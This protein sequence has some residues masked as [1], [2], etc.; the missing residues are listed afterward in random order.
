MVDKPPEPESMTHLCAVDDSCIFWINESA[1]TGKTTIAYTVAEVCKRSHVLSASL[2]CSCDDAECSNPLL[3]FTTIAYQ[4][5]MYN[6]LFGDQVAEVLRSQPD[7]GSAD[8]SFQLEELIANP[9]C[10]LGNSF[11]PCLGILDALDE[12]NESGITSLILSS[13]SRH[14][15]KLSSLCFLVTSH[16]ESHITTAF[17]CNPLSS[18]TQ[19]LILH[20]VQLDIVQNDI[21]NYLSSRFTLIDWYIMGLKKHGATRQTS[22]L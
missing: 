13:L 12:C 20:E 14:V 8:L 9:L 1:G 10:A 15:D 19:K 5:A 22:R 17:K 7:I 18:V 11:S 6:S 16:P 21:Q 3:I 2:F 4:L